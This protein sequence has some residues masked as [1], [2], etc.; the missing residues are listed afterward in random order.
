MS[1]HEP[2]PVA[3]GAI[4]ILQEGIDGAEAD[5]QSDSDAGERVDLFDYEISLPYETAREIAA[6]LRSAEPIV[7]D[8]LTMQHSSGFPDHFTRVRVCQRE[9]TLFMSKIRGRCEYHAAELNWLLNGAEK[10]HILNFSDDEPEGLSDYLKSIEA[11]T[12]SPQPKAAE[13]RPTAMSEHEPKPV[14]WFAW[15][16]GNGYEEVPEQFQG[17]EWTIPLYPASVVTA[18]QEEVGRLKEE[19]GQLI[20]ENSDL[21]Y[22]PW[23]EWA[24]AVL[25]VIRKHSGYDGY[26][27]A[28]EGVDMPL[29]LSEHLS[30]MEAEADRWKKKAAAAEARANAAEQRLKEAVKLARIAIACEKM[31]NGAA[32]Y[33]AA[34]GERDD[35]KK[36]KKS[37]T[38]MGEQARAFIKEA[39][40]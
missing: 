31:M 23:P 20:D 38:I 1:E 26:D 22:E 6:L 19:N 27:D 7:C 2:K 37:A 5:M 16:E 30:E 35:A 9:L 18:L 33:F 36:L 15:D 17:E 4:H 3:G 13:R 11:S 40:E 32:I 29:E 25:S 34:D 39:G 14:G 12:P 21:R 28:T 8:V 10:P 24:K